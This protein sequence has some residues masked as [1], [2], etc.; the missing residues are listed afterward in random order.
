ML[1]DVMNEPPLC[2]AVAVAALPDVFW[3]NVGNVQLAKLP[4]D[5]VPNAGDTK[6]GLFDNT[7]LPEPV[8]VVT[9]VPP[10]ATGKVPVTPEVN[11][12]P[13]A[14]VSVTE[15][16]VPNAGVTKVGLFE[17]TLLPDPVEVV[18]PVPPFATGSVPVTPL[19]SGSPVTFVITPEAGVPKA[20]VTS[21]GEVSVPP[22]TVGEIKCV[23]CWVKFV[24]SLHTVIVLPAGIATPV[25]AAVVLPIMV[26]L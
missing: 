12:N 8:D 9:P 14:F 13:V 24:P 6:V 15:E 7:L 17:S 5:G 18:T 19:V 20:G 4:D 10:F 3:F 25:P 1:L 23:F 11:G 16:G 21:V 2:G 22:A 26:E